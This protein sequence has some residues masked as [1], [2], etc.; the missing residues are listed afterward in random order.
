MP[1]IDDELVARA[2]HWCAVAGQR[3]SPEEVRAALAPLS[4]DQ[5]LAVRACL[6]DPP[7][8]NLPGSLALAYLGSGA[9]AGAA[10]EH[11]PPGRPPPPGPAP[12]AQGETPPARRR[13]A[14]RAAHPVGP[15]IHR[16]VDRAPPSAPAAPVWAPL[17]ELSRS[18]GRS[19]LERLVREHGARR[20]PLLEA[21][22]RRWRRAD[23]GAPD[24]EDLTRL[25][26]E[27]GL[28]RTFARRER[29]EILHDLRAAGGDRLRA[30]PAAG[31]AT[32]EALDAAL[33]RLGATAQAEAIREAARR[34]IRRRATLT[35]RA[36]VL[37]L[38]EEHLRDL[39]LLAAI[40]SDLAA[41]L[42][43]H[44]RAL[45]ASGTG[46]VVAALARSL[47]LRPADAQA[48]VRRLGLD[49]EG[50]GA[51]GSRDSRGAAPGSRPR[52]RQ[53]PRPRR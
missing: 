17:D 33:A 3:A 15:I 42:P 44:L 26:A 6:A 16:A 29:D 32:A 34:E 40:E 21:M 5:L 49:A 10:A 37:L 45:R 20:G 53:R 48:L 13:R 23:G 2:V 4:W 43:E 1:E 46:P 50:I 47:S 35:E 38:E 7:P 11:E 24:D 8:G 30:A 18:E 51:G 28:S 27:H 19:T 9:S 31:L 39:G 25:L 52:R 36:R 12:A 14:A 22:R 41:R